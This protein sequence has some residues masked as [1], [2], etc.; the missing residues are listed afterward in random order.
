MA[1]PECEETE[2]GRKSSEARCL[3]GL[4]RE[5]EKRDSGYEE[6]AF[7]AKISVVSSSVGDEDAEHDS[8]R[9]E[10]PPVPQE[11]AQRWIEPSEQG[12]QVVDPT[13]DRP[14]HCAAR[15]PFGQ[16]V[17]PVEVFDR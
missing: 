17:A 16:R 12:R 9:K 2:H 13:E 4:V 7:I 11:K 14:S 10:K 15:N 5:P 8:S 6:R 3:D 1:E